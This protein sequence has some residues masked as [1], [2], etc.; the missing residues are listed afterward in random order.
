MTT[1]PFLPHHRRRRLT[2]KQDLPPLPLGLI[3]RAHVPLESRARMQRPDER[4]LLLRRPGLFRGRG[5]SGGK[6]FEE[7]GRD[8]AVEEETTGGR[9]SLTG[10]PERCKE[11]GTER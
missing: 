7:W 10:R 2:T 5:E 6:G 1:F 9:T 4:A 8:A 3:H 11:D